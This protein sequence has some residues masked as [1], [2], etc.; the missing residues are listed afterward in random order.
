MLD[1]EAALG[2]AVMAARRAHIGLAQEE[3]LVEELLK[4]LEYHPLEEAKR[5]FAEGY[6]KAE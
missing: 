3:R 1:K 5:V 6:G 4:A 2:Y